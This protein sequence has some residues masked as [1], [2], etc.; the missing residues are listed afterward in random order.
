VTLVPVYRVNGELS[1]DP[2]GTFRIPTDVPPTLEQ[3][4]DVINVA[5][6]VSD[7][8]VIAAYRDEHRDRA[9]RWTWSAIPAPLRGLHP[10][11]LDVQTH[12]I[13]LNRRRLRLDNELGLV[14]EKGDV[15]MS[16]DWFE[17]DL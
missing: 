14:I 9:L 4:K 8:A 5:V 12:S 2:D 13:T 16:G 1:L 15:D 17:E 10:L 7:R 3:M 6:P 11:P